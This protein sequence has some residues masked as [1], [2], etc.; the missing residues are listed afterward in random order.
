MSQAN[1]LD[2]HRETVRPDW[3]DYN[4]QMNVAYYVLVFDHATDTFLDVIGLDT[5]H[6]EATG[7]SVFVA[8]AHVTYENE[9]MDGDKLRITTQVL[10]ADAKRMHIFHRMYANDSDEVA[11]TNELMILG[12]DLAT[13]RVAPMGDLVAANLTAMQNAHATLPHPYQA[14]RAIGIRRG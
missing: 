1:P 13:R 7:N 3:V 14:G 5:V 12:V 6:R 11:A 4:G 8:E 10:D 9:V 2:L